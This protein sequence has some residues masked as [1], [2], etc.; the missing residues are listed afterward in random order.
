VYKEMSL[1]FLK[2]FGVLI[3][4]EGI[5]ALMKHMIWITAD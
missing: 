5:F 4:E 3:G 1:D 2:Q